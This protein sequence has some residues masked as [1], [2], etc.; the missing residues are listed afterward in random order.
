M[1]PLRE[2]GPLVVIAEGVVSPVTFA[3]VDVVKLPTGRVLYS[4]P[5]TVHIAAGTIFEVLPLKMLQ[6]RQR[7]EQRA[8]SDR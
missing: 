4:D 7:N 1:R 8:K 3:G 2:I 5:I 6:E